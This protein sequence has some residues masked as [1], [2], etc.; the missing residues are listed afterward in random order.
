MGLAL[1]DTLGNLVSGLALQMQRPFDVGDWVEFEGAQQAG[2]VTEV[3]WRATSI[4]TVDQVEVILPN[5]GLAKAAI[6]N[7]SRPSPVLNGCIEIYHTKHI[8]NQK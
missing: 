8:H 4:M 3:T 1:Q 7:Y 6:R 2:R 5:A